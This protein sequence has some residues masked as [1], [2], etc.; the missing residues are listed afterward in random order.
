M[1]TNPAFL[2][3]L[4]G[5]PDDDP[6][7]RP[8]STGDAPSDRQTDD[9]DPTTDRSADDNDGTA[10]QDTAVQHNG[11]PDGSAN[12]PAAAAPSLYARIQDVM[13]K[14]AGIDASNGSTDARPHAPSGPLGGDGTA[15]DEPPVEPGGPSSMFDFAEGEP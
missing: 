12:S 14:T 1:S 10:W 5:P 9:I 8:T 15:G 3:G 6:L 4:F 2:K 13:Q 7:L 11:D